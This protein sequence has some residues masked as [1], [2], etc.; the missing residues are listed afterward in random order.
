MIFTI[1]SKSLWPSEIQRDL[2]RRFGILH[3]NL[4]SDKE[5]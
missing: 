5:R 4:S 1:R 2:S 3:G